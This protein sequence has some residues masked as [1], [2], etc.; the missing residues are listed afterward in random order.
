MAPDVPGIDD[1]CQANLFSADKG[2]LLLSHIDR[3]MLCGLCRI[4]LWNDKNNYSQAQSATRHEQS[5]ETAS[6]HSEVHSEAGQIGRES[7]QMSLAELTFFSI[8]F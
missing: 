5:G 8:S 7:L 1:L 6:A 3:F 2:K 4:S